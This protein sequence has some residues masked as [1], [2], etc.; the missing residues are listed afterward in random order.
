M[1]KN[2]QVLLE[3]FTA[4]PRNKI[5]QT[6]ILAW[7]N[8]IYFDCIVL[9]ENFIGSYR[10]EAID[11]ALENYHVNVNDQKLGVWPKNVRS[12]MRKFFT[13]L[14]CS[15][16]VLDKSIPTHAFKAK[17]ISDV[18]ALAGFAHG[19]II[20]IHP[21]AIG[22]PRIARLLANYIALRYGL[23]AFIRI[24]PEP[25]KT[26]YTIAAE[27]SIGQPPKFRPDHEPVISLFHSM[28]EHHLIAATKN[29]PN[30]S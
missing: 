27:K 15:L 20:R 11:E 10:G 16:K 30:I 18:V 6:Q 2:I 24:E 1:S 12:D 25:N 19:E 4:I 26:L 23:P 8:R 29:E 9:N 7:H 3:E 13:K 17:Q 14:N 21:F 22:S 5:M 28:L